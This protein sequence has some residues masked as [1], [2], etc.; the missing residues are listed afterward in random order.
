[1]LTDTPKRITVAVNK[2]NY[3][4]DILLKT[5]KLN[6]SMLTQNDDFS[7]FKR[8]GFVS[9]KDTNKFEDMTGFK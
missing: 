7:T 5:K 3:S 6:V 8:F 2:Q 4:H 1:M 9:G